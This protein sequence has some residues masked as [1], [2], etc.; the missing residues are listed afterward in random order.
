MRKLHLLVN[1]FIDSWKQLQ[2]HAT[3]LH[4]SRA[5]ARAL[6]ACM[7]GAGCSNGSNMSSMPIASCSYSTRQQVPALGHGVRSG[8]ISSRM[9]SVLPALSS[10]RFT[11]CHVA[12][13]SGTMRMYRLYRAGHVRTAASKSSASSKP[14]TVYRCTECGEG[15]H[16]GSSYAFL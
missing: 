2:L 5:E 6:N 4:H 9:A 12:N 8:A 11:S 13:P 7:A 14:K 10:A 15:D 1:A 3:Y 16:T